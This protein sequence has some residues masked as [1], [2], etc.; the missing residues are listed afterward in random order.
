VIALPSYSI[1]YCVDSRCQRRKCGTSR[2][3][4][5]DGVRRLLVS[6]ASCGRRYSTPASRSN[7]PPTVFGSHCKCG[8]ASRA[9]VER[10]QDEAS[11]MAVDAKPIAGAGR[12]QG[13]LTLSFSPM[14]EV[15]MALSLPATQP[16]RCIQFH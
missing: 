3:G 1:T 5:G 6:M 4:M 12:P 2:G 11:Q 10:D 8:V 13:I 14:V 7:H 9:G 16:H 15:R